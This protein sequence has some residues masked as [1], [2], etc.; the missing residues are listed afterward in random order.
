MRQVLSI[1]RILPL[2]LFFLLLTLC[3]E[4]QSAIQL[5]LSKGMRSYEKQTITIKAAS[6][7]VC[8]LEVSS[9]GTVWWRKQGIRV[10][11][12]NNTVSWDGCGFDGEYL[13]AAR[14]HMVVRFTGD[15]GSTGEDDVIFTMQKPALALLYFIPDTDTLWL[16]SGKP[17]YFVYQTT[18]A[19]EVIM[20]IAPEND[21]QQI[22]G[23]VKLEA[24]NSAARSSWNGKLN[25]KALEPGRYLITCYARKAPSWTHESILTI[26]EGSP[27]T[28][29]V[30]V[31]GAIMPSRNASDEE[32]WEM[33]TA[34]A[35]VFASG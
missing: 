18:S 6:D 29:E 16:G 33:M 3:A 8:D 30:Q 2:L 11:A 1:H 35:V 24:K 12:G 20:Q 5:K 13:H 22:L 27:D 17:W 4:A 32:I 10:N 7:G 15:D 28:P 21:P 34:P 19:A 25:G 26:S 31:T 23:T 9:S 14:F